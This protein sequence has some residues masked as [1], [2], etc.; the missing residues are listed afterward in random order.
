ML[1]KFS[2]AAAAGDTTAGTAATSLGDQ[3][4]TTAVTTATI[5]NLFDDVSAAEATAGDVEYRCV[6]V[7]NNHATDT[8]IG[9]TVAVQSQVS[10]GASFDLAL[11]NVAI[12][13]KASASPQAA[14]I[15]AEGTTPTPVGTFGAGPL[16]IGDMAPGTV[17]GVWVRRTVTASTAALASDG[18]VIRIAGEG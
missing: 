16:T 12:S 13:A 5:G 14:V 17:K 4:S 2:V 1:L 8:A 10:L 7:H 9:V 18:G 6:F 11:D 15:G 3:V